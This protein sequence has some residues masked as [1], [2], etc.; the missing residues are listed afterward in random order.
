M[1]GFVLE[2]VVPRADISGAVEP[3]LVIVNEAGDIVWQARLES[4]SIPLAD[5]GHWPRR[6]ASRRDRGSS[7]SRA[8]LQKC[9]TRAIVSRA[10]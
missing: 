3:A 10:H 5:D 9:R 1:T 6:G 4:V 8:G 7:Y 2:L